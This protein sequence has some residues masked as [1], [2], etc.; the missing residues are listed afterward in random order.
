MQK[1]KFKS[2]ILILLIGGFIVKILGFVV[3][4]I[5]TRIIGTK[6]LSLYTIVTPTYSLLITLAGF[7]L[8][9][10]IS[11][12]INERRYKNKVIIWS[13]M[14]LMIILNVIFIIIIFLLAPFLSN[15]LLKEP[16]TYYLL[17]AMSF[18]LP[19][20]SITSI[21][22]GYFLGKMNVAPNTVSNIFEQIVRILFLLFILPILVKKS[23]L[24]GV[25]S[26]ILLNIISEIVSIIVFSFYLP[27]NKYIKLEEIKPHKKIIKDIL[28]TSIPSVSSRFIGNIGFFLEPIILTN[29]LLYSGYSNEY[30]LREYAAYNAYAIG[31]LTLPSFFIAAICQ[32]L[33]PEISKYFSNNNLLMVKRRLKQ[34]LFYSFIIGTTSS[35]IIF[36]FRNVFLT[37]LYNT[38]LGSNYIFFLAPFFVLFY[39]EAPLMSSLQ[40]IGLAKTS[41]KITFKGE[42][43]K[44]CLL[45]ILSLVHIGLFSLVIAEI[46]NIFYVVIAS[47][48][49]LKKVV[50]DNLVGR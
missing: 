33:I 36:I 19:F 6:G 8:P 38:T 31:L 26:L 18:T 28:D 44:L 20:I 11:K 27:K 15:Y 47:F 17:I 40:A 46:I 39:L 43:I 1:D 2:S 29:F 9:I 45:A 12:L 13:T 7:A 24:L 48:N 41:M 50:L 23:L 5:Y 4:I 16:N 30:I 32:I 34:A 37:T 21:L 3:K 10:S 25:I 14:W 22:R 42:I 35:I 49:K